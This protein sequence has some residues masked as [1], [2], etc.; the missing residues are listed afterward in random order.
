M[1]DAWGIRNEEYG[2]GNFRLREF[3]TQAWCSY[4]LRAKSSPSG[5]KAATDHVQIGRRFWKKSVR[6]LTRGKV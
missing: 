4:L 5:Q 3:L 6:W 2:E 1:V